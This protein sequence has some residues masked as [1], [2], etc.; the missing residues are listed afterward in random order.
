MQKTSRKTLST[1]GLFTSILLLIFSARVLLQF[2]Q[3]IYPLAIL[4]SFESWHSGA[5]PYKFLL[6]TQVCIIIICII[7][8]RNFLQNK[9]IAKRKKGMIYLALGGIYFTF[10]AIR[11]ILGLTIASSHSWFG[12]TI[13]SFF[14]LILASIVLVL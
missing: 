11:L 1:Y 10:M 5:L 2:I 7:I 6:L 3:A 13:P 4:P 9:I 8:I 14:H 12:A